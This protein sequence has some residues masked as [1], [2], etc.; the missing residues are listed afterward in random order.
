MKRLLRYLRL[1][2]FEEQLADELQGHIEEVVERYQAAG[3]TPDEA[4]QAALRDFGNRT[5]V[6]ENCREEWRWA[7]LDETASDLRYA[8]RVLLASPVFTLVAISSLALGIGIN[9]TVF[10]AIDRVLIHALPYPQAERLVSLWGRTQEGGGAHMHVSVADFDDWRAQS[11]AF[12]GLSAFASWPMNLTGVDEPRRLQTELVS[13]NLFD[14]LEARPAVGRTFFEAEERPE[15]APVVV[16]SHA[17]WRALGQPAMGRTLTLNNSPATVIGVM[18]ASFSFPSPDVDAWVPLSLTAAN[19]ANREGRWL[20]VIGRLANGA[21]LANAQSEMELIA[22]RLAA[23]HPATNKGWSVSLVPLHDQVTGRATRVL[24]TLQ[25]GALVLL[26]ITC[27][28]LA[29]LLLARGASRGREIA[30]RTALGADRWRIVRQLLVESFVLASLG[31]GLGIALA[32]IGTRILRTVPETLLPRATEISLSAP[33]L[34]A[35]IAVT[36]LTAILFGVAPALSASR[37]D[38][39]LQLAS[40]LRGTPFGADRKRAFLMAT[41]IGMAAMLLVCAGLLVTSTVRLL[42]ID[43]GIQVNGLLTVRLTLPHSQ[44]PTNAAQNAVFE[45]V[46]DNVRALPGVSAVAEISDT[47][48]AGNNPTFEMLLR[49]RRNPSEL[50]IRAGLRAISPGYLT[51]AGVSLASGRAFTSDDRAD[52]PPVGIVNQTMARQA[53]PNGDAVGS[54]VR[55]KDG[56]AWVTVVGVVPDVKQLG[57]TEEEGPVLYI[58]YAQNRQDWMSWT[59]LVIRANTEPD[60]LLPSIRKAIHAVD[61]NVPIAEVD[62]LNK[63]LSRSTAIPRFLAGTAGFLSAFSLLVAVIGIYGLL[64]YNVARRIPEIGI[65]ITLGASGREI[66]RLLLRQMMTPVLTGLACGLTVAWWAGK[67]V[68]RQ[69][70]RVRPH[71]PSIFFGVAASLAVASLVAVLGPTRRAR[72][73]DPSAALRAG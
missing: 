9:A 43:P 66:S 48:L 33:V 42:S 39:N 51:A 58:P 36:A 13:A 69:L 56:S 15:S 14:V 5:L 59:T 6:A 62:D 10:S 53:W 61:K 46:L 12:T 54:R 26:L 20:Q 52:T 49:E 60:T 31:G 57:L 68:E 63:L 18:P 41:E 35:A 7:L 24:W 3:F 37:A 11:R 40:G 25:I 44:Y 23:A 72:H 2:R 55:L 50:P 27:A 38:L 71:E 19:R 17:L 64:T 47:P 16:L 45:R 32:V 8:A 4:R 21:R 65:R 29:N 28:N 34:I 30:M 67:F 70:F 73:I 1:Q 22:R